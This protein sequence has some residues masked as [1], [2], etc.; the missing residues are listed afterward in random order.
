M[1][2]GMIGEDGHPGHADDDIHIADSTQ[3][4]LDF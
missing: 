1:Q 3:S 2:R 4:T